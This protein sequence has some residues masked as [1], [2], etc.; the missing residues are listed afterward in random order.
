MRKAHFTEHQIIAVSKSL[1]PVSLKL[2]FISMNNLR[3]AS[4]YS[5]FGVLLISIRNQ[6]KLC[7]NGLSVHK[8]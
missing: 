2:P 4:T 7:Q 5:V 6:E 1:K 8:M 3:L